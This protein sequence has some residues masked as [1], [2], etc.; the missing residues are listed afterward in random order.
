MKLLSSNPFLKG[1]IIGNVFFLSYLNLTIFT[2]FLLILFVSF[3][4]LREK[5]SFLFILLLGVTF[6]LT[7]L[8]FF[9][10][11]EGENLLFEKIFIVNILVLLSA[12]VIKYDA[13]FVSGLC[14]IIIFFFSIDLLI[15]IPSFILR[16]DILN[17]TIDIREDDKVRLNGILGHPFLSVAISLIGFISFRILNYNNLSIFPLLN[18]VINQTNRA[19]IVLV[20]IITFELL[21]RLKKKYLFVNGLI[22]ATIMAYG[23]FMMTINSDDQSNILRFAAWGNSLINIS[24]SPIYGTTNFSSFDK[25][26]GVSENILEDSG[27][28]ENQYLEIALHWGVP[29]ALFYLI[30][31]VTFFFYSVQNLNNDSPITYYFAL[32]SFV[33][34]ADSIWGNLMFTGIIVF[35]YATLFSASSNIVYKNYV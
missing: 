6:V 2:P 17:R 29:V 28:A 30:I 16:T 1:I 4:Q 19:Q 31:L 34:L 21:Y 3:G 14:Y 26:N 27:I 9:I 33:C 23:I 8:E 12:C 5:F 25:D 10:L 13:D 22:V 32:I 11:K 7:T 18:L 35:F 15:N 24:E 20:L